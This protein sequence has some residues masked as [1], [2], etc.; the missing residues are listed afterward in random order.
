MALR[1][2]RIISWFFPMFMAIAFFAHPELCFGGSIPIPTQDPV[3]SADVVS[4]LYIDK[5]S[6]S[7]DS[8]QNVVVALSDRLPGEL[9]SAELGL[10]SE[11]SGEQFASYGVNRLNAK[12]ALFSFDVRDLPQAQY[13]ISS[14]VLTTS[15]GVYSVSFDDCPVKSFDVT[16]ELAPLSVNDGLS[17]SN[18][19]ATVYSLGADGEL[20][21]PGSFD[22]VSMGDDARLRSVSANVV[23]LDPGHGGSDPGAVSNGHRE[24][25]LVWK[26]ANYCKDELEATYGTRVFLTRRGGECPSLKERA[27]R[28]KSAGASILVSFHLN[29]GGGVG[30]EVWVP[31]NS[32]YNSQ[33]HTVGTDLAKQI[34]KQLELLGLKN[35]GVKTRDYPSDGSAASHYPDGSQADYFGIIREARRLGVAGIIVEHAFIDSKGDFNQFLSSEAMLKALGMADAK[36]IATSLGLSADLESNYADVYDYDYYISKYPDI[37]RAFGG[38]KTRTF[39][40][41]L[42]HGMDEGRQGSAEFDLT[43]Y[44]KR[45]EDLRHAFRSDLKAYY[46][47]YLEY[48]KSEGRTASHFSGPMLGTTSWGGVDYSP[49]YNPDF[50]GDRYDDVRR[51]AQIKTAFVD[52]VDD[53]LLLDHFRSFGMREGR[54]GSRSFEVASYYNSHVDLRKA[55]GLDLQSYYTHYLNYGHDEGRRSLGVPELLSYIDNFKSVSYSDVYDAI[56]YSHNY[57]DLNRAFTFKTSFVSLVDD[58]GLIK[59]F[60]SFGMKEGR[61]ASDEFNPKYYRAS[62]SDLNSAFGDSMSLY[63]KHY[64]QFG[65]KEGRT[66]KGS[67]TDAEYEQAISGNR[68]M[69]AALTTPDQMARL[70]IGTV[71]VGRYP[72]KIYSEKGAGSISDFCKILYQEAVDEGVRPEVVFCQVMHETGWLKFGGQVSPH[73]CNFGGLGADNSGAAGASFPD[74]RT[75]IRAQVQH[76]KAYASKNPLKHACVDPRFNLVKRGCAPRITDLNG[77]WAVPGVGYGEAIIN[78]MSKLLKA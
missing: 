61:R 65:K 64:M 67:I 31:N 5:A 45:Y 18:L 62:Y 41:F 46:K 50:Y 29:S 58:S 69:G 74:V 68:I 47:H 38:D 56:Y 70:F 12:M 11:T 2:R 20:S 73:Q 21:D 26:I 53:Q 72:T 25:D 27:A 75:G 49:I 19:S 78:L 24:S 6:I 13:S 9:T 15:L 35:R 63:Y 51:A 54:Q 23:A 22:D 43:A 30:S 7:G 44:Y 16:N 3:P 40:H 39:Q 8:T 59:H 32:S 76:L 77:R 66:G 36:G 10:A 52:L 33:L 37:Q 17:S 55:F 57:S 71:G 48:G 60:A 42:K 34:L 4:F 28:A 1:M 14:L